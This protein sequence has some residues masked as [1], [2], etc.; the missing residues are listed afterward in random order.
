MGEPM[1]KGADKT[2]A[3]WTRVAA[4]LALV[5]LTATAW[6]TGPASAAGTPA[7]ASRTEAPPETQEDDLPPADA[8]PFREDITGPTGDETGDEL[9]TDPGRALVYLPEEDECD[10]EEAVGRVEDVR[11]A[12]FEMTC[13]SAR[14]VDGLFGDDHDFAERE[15]GG[16]VRLGVVWNQY[17][18]LDPRLR[19]SV[20]TAFPNLSSRLNAFVGRVDEDNYISDSVTDADRSFDP[21]ENDEDAEWLLGLGYDKRK[22]DKQGWD[23]SVGIRFRFPPR[24]YVRARWRTQHSFGENADVAF[25][26]TFFWRDGIGFGTT[27]R[28]DTSRRVGEKDVL[29]FEAVGT[30]SEDTEGVDWWAGHTWYHRLDEGRGLSLLT[31]ARGE[32]RRDP[33]LTEYGFHLI[34]RRPLEREWLFLNAGP[35][36]TWPRFEPDEDREMSWGLIA[37]VEMFF[38]NRYR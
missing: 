35:T 28:F 12:L 23:Y 36:L 8:P 37:Q 22:A 31:F 4:A 1:S 15:V 33:S 18:G 3:P 25:R 5:L 26:Q 21:R 10:L 14:W 34:Y 20:R 2:K 13:Y 9:T 27:S 30:W 6:A 24:P 11:E 7:A 38:G 32:S 19:F 29:Q 16:R 17:D